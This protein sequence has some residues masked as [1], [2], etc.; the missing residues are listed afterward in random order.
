MLN[1]RS[2][3]TGFD[4]AVPGTPES[5]WEALERHPWNPQERSLI[6]VA[7]HPDDETLGAG[8]LIHHYAKR[9]LRVSIISVTDGEAACPEVTDLGRRRRAELRAALVTL[10]ACHA[11]II[12]LGIPDG[13]VQGHS[14]ELAQ[15]LRAVTS[16]DS[17][18]I[19]P[20]EQDGHPDHD[21]AGQ[22]ARE[23]AREQGLTVAAYP[24]WAWHQ[25]APGVFSGRRL[26]SLSL[27]AEARAAKQSAIHCYVSQLSERT[28]GPIVP[29]HVL[30]YF[31]RP[32]ET[33]LL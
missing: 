18:I 25:A 15:A 33:F 30:A 7:P 13:R 8:G 11:R 1:T 9:Q 6:V 12:R 21:T 22:V 20:F 4:R 19:A 28:G 10:G 5:C 29:P 32:Y 27:G 24:I 3:P 31:E 26:V 23:I 17:L 2:I 16:H 14:T